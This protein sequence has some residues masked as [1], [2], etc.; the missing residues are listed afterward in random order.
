MHSE[1]DRLLHQRDA[2]LLLN[3]SEYWLER[4]RSRGT[5]PV[6]VKVGRSVRYRLKDLLAYIEQNTK[7]PHGAL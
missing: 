7:R 1:P 3:M 2:A 5:G 6:F 4:G